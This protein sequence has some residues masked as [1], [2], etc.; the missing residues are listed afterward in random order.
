MDVQIT[1]L[2]TKR[3]CGHIHPMHGDIANRL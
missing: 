3:G 1:Q 2:F